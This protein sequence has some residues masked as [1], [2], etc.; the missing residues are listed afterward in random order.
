[1][2]NQT[3][4][5]EP[6]SNSTVI[7]QPARGTTISPALVLT[8]LILVVASFQLNATMLSPAVGDMAARL[9]TSDGVIGW[10]T[11][12]FLAV[13]SALAILVPPYADQIG[14]RRALIGSLVVMFIGTVITLLGN[15]PVWLI[16][17]RALQGF[18][19]STFALSNLTLRAT[20]EPKKYGAAIGLVAAVNSGVGGIDTLIGGL[21]V[22][23]VGYKGIFVV[24]LALEVLALACVL[25]F[26]PETRVAQVQK[27]DWPGA[28]TMTG[29]LWSLTTL[30]TLGFSPIGWSSP[31]TLGFLFAAIVL[32]AAFIIIEGRAAI[33]LMPLDI[34]V[35]RQ[36]WGLLGTTFCTLASAFAVLMYAIPAL[37]QSTAGG[38]GMN[39]TTSALMYLTPFSL[40]GWLLAPVA[41]ILAP[42]LGYRLVLRAGLAGSMILMI[43]MVFGIGDRWMLFALS[44]LMGATYAAA[45]GTTLNGL[46]VLYSLPE[47]PGVLPG[48]NSAAFNLGASVGIGLMASLVLSAESTG[49]IDGYRN[50]LIVGAVFGVLAFVFSLV[51]PGRSSSSEKI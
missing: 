3:P 44:L 6:S 33:P 22:D 27:M 28:L 46:G 32:G 7:V 42:R 23:S 30:L 9:G 16:L 10:S 49:A 31:W 25:R 20:L 40:L 8:A 35:Q 43:L 14:R 4:T 11:T 29:G 36:T 38:F 41:G 34:L 24:I 18:C 39:G 37:S 17:G 51:L 1:M 19:G 50:A 48:L 2:S 21:I 15:D 26:V 5:A 47:R 12:V 45:S 13:A